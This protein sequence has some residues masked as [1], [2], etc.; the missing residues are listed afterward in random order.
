MLL[1]RTWPVIVLLLAS[2]VIALRSIAADIDTLRRASAPFAEA[3]RYLAADALLA[4]SSLLALGALMAGRS[5]IRAAML[6]WMVTLLVVVAWVLFI[7]IGTNGPPIWVRLS[8]WLGCAV[9]SA[10]AVYWVRRAWAS[11]GRN[12]AA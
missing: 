9:L 12:A 3:G 6:G 2:A 8:V 4:A 7:A 1:R 10:I 11:D 5:W